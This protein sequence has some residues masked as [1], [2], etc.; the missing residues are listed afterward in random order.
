MPGIV[1]ARPASGVPR[2]G[3]LLLRSFLAR[4]RTS[5]HRSDGPICSTRFIG[6]IRSIG[7][8]CFIRWLGFIRSVR[9]SG[10]RPFLRRAR[11]LRGSALRAGV[12]VVLLLGVTAAVK[13]M[14]E[15]EAPGAAQAAEFST[16]L[17]PVPATDALGNTVA[18]QQSMG[19]AASVRAPADE[20]R[21]LAAQEA[22]RSAARAAAA[23]QAVDAKHTADVKR[24]A[25]AQKTRQVADAAAVRAAAARAAAARATAA[26]AAAARAEAARAAA[27][28]A[29]AARAAAARAAAAKASAARAQRARQTAAT[30]SVRSGDPRSIARQLLATRGWSGQFSC[31]NALWQRESGWNPRA[32]NPSSGA[33]G[34]PQALPGGKMASAGADWRTDPATQIRWG[35]S[36]IASRY[37]TPCGAWAHSQSNGWY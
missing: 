31:L 6:S 3:S 5:S 22:A 33:Y 34:I 29:A 13:G 15:T 37:G 7:S 16:A 11:A 32:M 17:G 28:R 12:G 9:L 4:P 19:A 25:A 2:K 8:S 18:R 21:V 1:A 26:R 14:T 30:A 36:Y 27:A 24:A 23:K 35:L 10:F 20:A